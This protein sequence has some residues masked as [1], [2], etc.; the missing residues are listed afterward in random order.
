VLDAWKN[1]S[2]AGSVEFLADGN[3]EFAKAIDLSLDLTG[4]GMG[5]R[6]KRYSM[7]VEDGVIRKLN[8][9][10]PGKFEVSSAEAMLGQL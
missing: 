8:V 3:A 5:T 9:E 10:A 2:N 6:S 1:V 7:L 4:A